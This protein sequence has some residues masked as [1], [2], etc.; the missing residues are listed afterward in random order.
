[1]I[2]GEASV[3]P[4]FYV[5]K[6][7]V[8]V[9]LASKKNLYYFGLVFI[10]VLG[11][12]CLPSKIIGETLY[13]SPLPKTVRKNMIAVIISVFSWNCPPQMLC[14]VAALSRFGFITSL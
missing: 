11:Y 13:L 9:K 6:K 3:S 1:M 14:G 7:S 2:K 8:N 10:A 12:S 5:S 4:F